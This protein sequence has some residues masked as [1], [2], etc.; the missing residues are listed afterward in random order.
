MT[1]S[2]LAGGNCI[3]IGPLLPTEAKLAGEGEE[4]LTGLWWVCKSGD[5]H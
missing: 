4:L 2:R 1:S 3:N 5:G